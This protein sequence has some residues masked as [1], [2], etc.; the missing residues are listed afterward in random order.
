[1][2]DS[3]IPTLVVMA[4]WPA[5]GRCKRR[6]ATDIGNE[7]ASR[8][9]QRLSA[10]TFAVAGALA[11]QGEVDLQVAMSGISLQSTRRYLSS[12]PPCTLVDQGKGNLGAR[13]H[14]QIHHARF[15]QKNKSVIL[16]GTDLADLCPRDLRKAILTLQHQP[17]VIGPSE[18]GGY[19]LLGLSP[20]VTFQPWVI[21]QDLADMMAE[22]M[23]ILESLN[24]EELQDIQMIGFSIKMIELLLFQ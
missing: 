23:L 10:H 3:P 21:D 22:R 15:S 16:I 17:L 11:E 18:D 20:V 9:Q 7:R 6:L 1:M 4:R 19:W 13:M 14:R 5:S 2:S 12:L 8:I 24:L